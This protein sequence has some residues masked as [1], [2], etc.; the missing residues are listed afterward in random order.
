MRIAQIEKWGPIGI[1]QVPA[2]FADLQKAVLINCE[3]ARIWIASY[4]SRDMIQPT[5]PGI[6]CAGGHRP[7]ARLGRREPD[8]PSESPVPENW[9]GNRPAIRCRE[10]R[11]DIDILK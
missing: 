10:G 2:I 11:G 5:V 4:G 3:I 7:Q 9:T 8:F 1:G 6:R